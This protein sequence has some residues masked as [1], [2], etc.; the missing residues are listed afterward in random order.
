MS[1]IHQR[2]KK[3]RIAKCKK[4]KVPCLQQ[5]SQKKGVC[6]KIFTMTPKKPNSAIRKVARVRLVNNLKITAYIPGE[7][8]NLQEYSIVLVRGGRAR[9]LP[10]VRYK[11]VRGKYDLEPVLNRKTRRSKYGIKQTTIS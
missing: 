8:H 1:T 3:T 4:N 7:G 10:S 6:L 5:N 11:V 2:L 9:D